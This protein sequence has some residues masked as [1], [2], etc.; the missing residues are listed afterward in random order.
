MTQSNTPNEMEHKAGEMVS[1]GEHFI[2]K[3]SK[4]ILYILLGVVVLGV[5]IWLYVE[6]VHKPR[7]ERASASLY[8][9]EEQFMAGADSLALSGESGFLAIAKEY[10]GTKAA[11]LAHAYA[12]IIYYDEG[13]YQEAIDELKKFSAKETMVAPSLTRLIGDCYVELQQYQEAVKYFEQAAKDADNAVVSP[14]CLIK[15]GRVY[16]ELG[17]ND[18]ALA[19]YQQIKDKYYTSA[20]ASSIDASIIR[21]QSKLG[22]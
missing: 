13:K 6:K 17:Q 19:V 2:E 11:K 7:V 22:K 1:K 4:L 21:V 8:Q 18:K 16:E 10:S 14:S 15:A 3:N 9:A 12:G 5:G 20:E